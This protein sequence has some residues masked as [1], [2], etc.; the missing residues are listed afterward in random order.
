MFESLSHRDQQ[1]FIEFASPSHYKR[2]GAAEAEDEK[3]RDSVATGSRILSSGPQQQQQQQQRHPK[4]VSQVA[5][6]TTVLEYVHRSRTDDR[7]CPCVLQE[8]FLRHLPRGTPLP[9]RPMTRASSSV[10]SQE[11]IRREQ[12]S[13]SMLKLDLSSIGQP[14]DARGRRTKA[15]VE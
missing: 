15:R 5:G 7:V 12:V 10:L 11:P 3:I 9:P 4:Q 8:G 13:H 1:K 14:G 2:A 6:G